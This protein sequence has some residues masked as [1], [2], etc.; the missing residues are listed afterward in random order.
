MFNSQTQIQNDNVIWTLRHPSVKC[1]HISHQ[2]KELMTRV[3]YVYEHVTESTG[4][5]TWI[6]PNVRMLSSATRLCWSL[7]TRPRSCPRHLMSCRSERARRRG[8]PLYRGQARA[9]RGRSRS[10]Q[11]CRKCYSVDLQSEN[12]R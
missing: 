6:S 9:R 8:D 2:T 4:T 1:C 3:T 7:S 12:G 10:P 11:D 5:R